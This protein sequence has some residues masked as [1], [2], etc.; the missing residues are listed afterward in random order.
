MSLFSLGVTVN[1]ALGREGWQRYF[2]CCGWAPTSDLQAWLSLESWNNCEHW[3]VKARIPTACQDDYRLRPLFCELLQV[4]NLEV[5]WNSA[6]GRCKQL[7]KHG[8]KIEISKTLQAAH[9]TATDLLAQHEGVT[10]QQPKVSPS[11]HWKALQVTFCFPSSDALKC[12]LLQ[13]TWSWE[14]KNRRDELSKRFV[15]GAEMLYAWHM[16]KAG[17]LARVWHRLL[18]ICFKREKN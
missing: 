16:S 14:A 9:P 3:Q 11:S 2:T 13:V 17:F 10:K 5:T 8:L 7:T 15:F 1:L 4:R 6:H 18:P 12:W